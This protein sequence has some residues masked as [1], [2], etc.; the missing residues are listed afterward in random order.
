[1]GALPL[2]WPRPR[3]GVTKLQI[4]RQ[5]TN[6]ALSVPVQVPGGAS[7]HECMNMLT[8]LQATFIAREKHASAEHAYISTH[9]NG[10]YVSTAGSRPAG[11]NM[12]KSSGCRFERRV[13]LH[14]ATGCPL[15]IRSLR[16]DDMQLLRAQPSRQLLLAMLI[17]TLSSAHLREGCA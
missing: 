7:R 6:T 4:D 14:Y 9:S 11:Y 3:A 2:Y 15:H 13:Q 8:C 16:S 5:C 10:T 1:M 12:G 17:P